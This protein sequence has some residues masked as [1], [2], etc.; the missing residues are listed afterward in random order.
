MSSQE[1]PK[2]PI[3]PRK[4]R[5]GESLYNATANETWPETELQRGLSPYS[6]P[7]FSLTARLARRRPARPL[8]RELDDQILKD[9]GQNATRCSAKR[10]RAFLG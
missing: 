1:M 9:I 7:A 2:V 3:Q 5:S 4:K 8:L 10:P 6:C